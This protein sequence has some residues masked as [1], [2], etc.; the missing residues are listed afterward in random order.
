MIIL[1]STILSLLL[2]LSVFLPVSGLVLLPAVFTAVANVLTLLA[3]LDGSPGVA[4]EH[5]N[6]L[7]Q[8]VRQNYKATYYFKQKSQ[9]LDLN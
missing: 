2:S 1:I 5:H 4:T 9:T 6:N 7:T 3:D 8:Q